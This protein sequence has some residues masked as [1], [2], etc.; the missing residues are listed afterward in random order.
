[1]QPAIR[2]RQSATDSRPL[3]NKCCSEE[4]SQLLPRSTRRA[5]YGP[6]G[7]IECTG[8]SYPLKW[9]FRWPRCRAGALKKESAYAETAGVVQIWFWGRNSRLR[10]RSGG[11]ID[12][13]MVD[14][15]EREF[16]AVGNTELVEN[17]VQVIL[18]RLLADKKFFADFLVAET[19]RDELHDF[20]FAVAEQG[21]FAAG[22]GFGRLREGLHDFGG[23]AIVEP[24]FAGVHA[25]DALHQQVR[26]RLLEDH[27]A[28]AEAHGANHIAIV[29]G[30][31]EHDDARRQGIEIDFLEDG[32]AVFIGHAQVKEKNIGLELGEELD[33]LRAILRF[34]DEG[35]VLVGIE[36]FTEAVAKNRV[37]VR[38]K[39]ANLLF[40][41]G[42][43]SRAEPR[44]SDALHG[45]GWTPRST[46]PP[47]Y[48]YAP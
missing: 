21:L 6:W 5:S 11:L 34:A 12:E 32:Q 2:P 41:L 7:S 35:Y 42:H 48:A 31:G 44:W 14:G 29:F 15:V 37:V 20:F 4:R 19:L 22:A 23:H 28:R 27:A 3:G 38:K 26:G 36:E 30:G 40:S 39:D 24:D 9:D 16:E 33:A 17:V 45:P 18:D 46:R 8:D 43:V 13:A 47:Q 1:M 25:V 10:G